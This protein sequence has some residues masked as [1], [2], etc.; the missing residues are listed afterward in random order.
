MDASPPELC[1][2]VQKGHY[3]AEMFA[4]AWLRGPIKESKTIALLSGT[5]LM[6]QLAG[7]GLNS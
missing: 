7:S 1:Q 2:P 3:R 6:L 4:Q 5:Q